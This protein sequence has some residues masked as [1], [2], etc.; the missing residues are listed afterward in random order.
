[1]YFGFS[2]GSSKYSW[3]GSD[4]FWTTKAVAKEV[5]PS[6]KGCNFWP[7]FQKVEKSE[8]HLQE[9]IQCSC[10]GAACA[11]LKKIWELYLCPEYRHMLWSNQ[12][13]HDHCE[14][15]NKSLFDYTL[16]PICIWKFN[17]TRLFGK[18]DMI[19][20][21][22]LLASLYKPFNGKAGSNGTGTTW[23]KNNISR[24]RTKICIHWA[25]WS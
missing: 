17:W 25:P 12:C 8:E 9:C 21:R 5:A 20:L 11:Q 13:V 4:L 24:M 2:W 10:E 3:T 7:A 18:H 1:M 15:I 14:S 6:Y 23:I 22:L 19:T 16:F